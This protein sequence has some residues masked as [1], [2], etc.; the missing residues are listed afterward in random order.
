MRLLLRAVALLTLVAL[1]GCGGSTGTVT[2]RVTFK[3]Q[4][5]AGAVVIFVPEAGIG[6]G[7]ATDSDGRYQLTSR[8]PGD[9]VKAGNCKVGFL[10]ADPVKAPLLIPPRLRD[11]ETSGITAVV[12]GGTNVLDFELPEK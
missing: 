9:G 8:S 2:G 6:A 4:P 10:P 5:L 11:P 7:G 1:A 3:G 12:K